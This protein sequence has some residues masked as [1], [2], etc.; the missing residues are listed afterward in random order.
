MSILKPKPTIERTQLRI[1]IDKQIVS[2]VERYCE[3][4]NFKKTDEFFEEAA[5]HILTRDKDFKEWKERA[6]QVV[7]SH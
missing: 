4:A 3:Y 1:S 6:E 2:D 7:E 5:L